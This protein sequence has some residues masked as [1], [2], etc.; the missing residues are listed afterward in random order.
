[1]AQAT[2]LDPSQPFPREDFCRTLIEAGHTEEIV[3]RMEMV[4]DLIADEAAPA[5][6]ADAIGRS[7]AVHESMPFAVYA[8]LR[9]TGS[10]EDCL[11]TAV[12]NGGDCDTLGAM[13]CAVSGAFLGVDAI[14][15]AWREKL[16]RRAAIEDLAKGLVALCHDP[17]G[18]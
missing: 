9:H 4:R 17:S 15:E 8:F 10:F 14:P 1:M 7:V 12:L 16:E 5:K 2:A 6:A 3:T 11:L 18:G 13:A